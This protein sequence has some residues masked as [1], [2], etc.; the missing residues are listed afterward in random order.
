MTD[1]E[2]FD[3]GLRL[4]TAMRLLDIATQALEKIA[5]QDFRG[6]RPQ[7]A[8]DAYHALKRMEDIN[9]S[10]VFPSLNYRRRN[11]AINVSL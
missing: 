8:E 6:N 11:N 2:A 1:K 7:S 4:G 3:I 9:K 10:I 5:N